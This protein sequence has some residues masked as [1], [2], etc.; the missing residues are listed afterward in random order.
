M[1]T[2]TIKATMIVDADLSDEVVYQLTSAIFDHAE[3]IAKEHAKGAELSVLNA[4]DGIS[5]PFHK[6][7]AKYF[8]EK[9]IEVKTYD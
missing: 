7:A 2:I 3:E 5:V 6:G 1:D 4:T 8:A 9:G